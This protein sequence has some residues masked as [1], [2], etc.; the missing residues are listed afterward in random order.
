MV[1][2]EYYGERRIYQV[3]ANDLNRL[4]ASIGG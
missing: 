1:F 2:S 4:S 3:D